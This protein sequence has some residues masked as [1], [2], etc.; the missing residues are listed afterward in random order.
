MSVEQERTTEVR[1][2][3]RTPVSSEHVSGVIEAFREENDHRL[4]TVMQRLDAV[5]ADRLLPFYSEAGEAVEQVEGVEPS[6][7]HITSVHIFHYKDGEYDRL[8]FVGPTPLGFGISD[9]ALSVTKYHATSEE[10]RDGEA[11]I[12]QTIFAYSKQ[13]LISLQTRA[14]LENTSTAIIHMPAR[15]WGDREALVFE[16]PDAYG[17]THGEKPVADDR[18][19][20]QKNVNIQGKTGFIYTD[21]HREGKPVDTL[22]IAEDLVSIL[23]HKDTYLVESRVV[24]FDPKGK[25][26]TSQ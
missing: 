9:Q 7:S 22:A 11:I 16:A 26:P 4:V 3:E 23:E 20:L 5:L 6:R 8:L 2:Q 1:E 17:Y 14:D 24:E 18:I 15:T 10:S 12:G 13:E 21:N 25:V 19:L